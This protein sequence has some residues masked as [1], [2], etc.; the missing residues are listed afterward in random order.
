MKHVM[1]SATQLGAIASVGSTEQLREPRSNAPLDGQL[2]SWHRACPAE[3]IGAY[4]NFIAS[5]SCE[6]HAVRQ[7]DPTAHISSTQIH[8]KTAILLP[9]AHPM[10]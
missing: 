9:K 2:Y 8:G 3:V 1:A 10:M 5:G 6:R 4:P 7:L